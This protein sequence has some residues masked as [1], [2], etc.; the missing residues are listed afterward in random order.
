MG[1]SYA[2][3]GC[4]SDDDGSP[5]PSHIRKRVRISSADESFYI[6]RNSNGPR[7]PSRGFGSS[8]EDTETSQGEDE[9]LILHREAIERTRSHT[10]LTRQHSRSI[11]LSTSLHGTTTNVP[12]NDPALVNTGQE[13]DSTIPLNAIATDDQSDSSI[14]ES[15]RE[16]SLRRSHS[17]RRP[18]I[19][20]T[21]N[22]S[23]INPIDGE[24]NN[25]LS[26]DVNTNSR[27]VG[28]SRSSSG[29][30]DNRTIVHGI[31]RSSRSSSITVPHVHSPNRTNIN[32]FNNLF[33][34]ANVSSVLGRENNSAVSDDDDDISDINNNLISNDENSDGFPA[35]VGSE[36]PNNNNNDSN[37]PNLLNSLQTLQN[38]L[39][40]SA[41]DPD[42]NANQILRS[43]SNSRSTS[44]VHSRVLS[45]PPISRVTSPTPSSRNRPRSPSTST[46][47]G[48]PPPSDYDIGDF[49]ARQTEEDDEHIGAI[50]RLENEISATS[51][52]NRDLIQRCLEVFNEVD[53]A[54]S[55]QYHERL[56]HLY[57]SLLELI[58]L[59]RHY[60]ALS[61]NE[62]SRGP[63][64]Q[65][66]RRRETS[67]DL[68][69]LANQENISH[70][71]NYLREIV[72]VNTDSSSDSEDNEPFRPNS[73]NGSGGFLRRFLERS[74]NATVGE[75]D[76]I[77]RQ[78]RVI[79]ILQPP[80]PT[81]VARTSHHI[82]SHTSRYVNH[83]RWHSSVRGNSPLRLLSSDHRLGSPES[84]RILHQMINRI[85]HEMMR[86]SLNTSQTT[87]I[88]SDE[89][90]TSETS[91]KALSEDIMD[92]NVECLVGATYETTKL[93]EFVRRAIKRRAGV[94]FSDKSVEKTDSILENAAKN[95]GVSETKTIHSNAQTSDNESDK[96]EIIGSSLT[97]RSLEES[98]GGKDSKK[99]R[100]NK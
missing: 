80:V 63:L 49:L 16:T 18:R 46:R 32:T 95:D 61:S 71:H 28:G 60:T 21:T 81:G 100:V 17:I 14:I 86:D 11:S 51:T 62:V 91:R 97:K 66:I 3:L 76:P 31:L 41:I 20:F 56:V 45:P 59:S 9:E 48:S 99:R 26:G 30:R 77:P 24:G 6:P 25:R 5:S 90:S 35:L 2:S 42:S 29:N 23:I 75:S 84:P 10:N 93:R 73:M 36:T 96:S 44:R 40:N 15:A 38:T 83:Q 89:P 57:I 8:S 87:N 7:N 37:N 34:D 69:N 43:R 33:V 55:H 98:D 4:D 52:A 72:S 70:D 88:E 78:D 94:S 64:N 74:N 85:S 82:S 53:G 67:T 68:R 54:N 1:I 50:Q 12:S 79:R 22:D 92:R 58:L 19:A 39:R 27:D 65:R 47:N 13:M